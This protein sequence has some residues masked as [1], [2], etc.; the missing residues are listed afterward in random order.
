MR[1]TAILLALLVVTIATSGCCRTCRNFFRRG[2][3]CGTTTV[4][5]PM[6][7]APRPLGSPYV[8]A[9]QPTQVVMPQ[10]QVVVPQM[11]VPQQPACCCPQPVPQCCPPQCC[12]PQCCEPCPPC[13]MPC[14]TGCVEG[15]GNYM[16][17]DC[18]C[19]GGEVVGQ[20]EWFGGYVEGSTTTTVIPQTNS[21]VLP[22]T[23]PGT[24]RNDPGPMN[25]R[26]PE[27]NENE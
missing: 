21:T 23:N 6:M 19:P 18:G 16:G 13:C 11:M 20:G 8:A 27:L 4:A 5:P 2:A 26:K 22:Q 14:E 12:P 1:K 3:P 10:N 25:N 24:Y 9:P 15:V 7:G 17:S